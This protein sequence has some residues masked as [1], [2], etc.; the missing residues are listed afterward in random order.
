M[1]LPSI[2]GNKKRL[3]VER[4]K[5]D[6][7]SFWFFLSS[8][9]FITCLITSNVIAVK[10]VDF[11]GIILPAAIIIFPISYIFGDILTEVYGYS[12]ARKVIWLGFLCN[13]IFV[14]F[15][16]VAKILPPASFWNGQEAYETILG[17]TPRLLFA[18]FVG[19]LF[20]EFSNSFVLAKLKIKTKGR[21]LWMRTIGSTIVGQGIDSALFITLAFYGTIPQTALFFTIINQWL[22]KTIYEA[23]FTPFT[24]AVTN[25]LKRKEGLDVFDYETK[26]NPLLIGQ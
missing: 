12:S 9:I 16:H 26:F 1:N 3:V 24:Y 5:K 15:C 19:Y 11:F 17:F 7:Y 20:G 25:F 22:T 2:S 21:F 8:S 18:S 13:L 4:G 10:L 14:L 23:L 6:S